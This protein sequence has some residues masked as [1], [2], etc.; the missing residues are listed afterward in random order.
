M[1]S[2]LASGYVLAE[3]GLPARHPPSRLLLRARVPSGWRITAAEVDGA[4]LP[5]DDHGTVDLSPRRGLV[6]VRFA[7]AR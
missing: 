3:A 7:V 6:S 2:H 1:E 4:S 5:V